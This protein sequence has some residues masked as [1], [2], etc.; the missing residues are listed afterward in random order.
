MCRVHHPWGLYVIEERD[1]LPASLCVT[2]ARRGPWPEQHHLAIV[3]KWKGTRRTGISDRNYPQMCPVVGTGSYVPAVPGGE[4]WGHSGR[5]SKLT[6]NFL[7]SL[8]LLLAHRVL[9]CAHSDL[10]V[11]PSMYSVQVTRFLLERCYLFTLNDRE[12]WAGKRQVLSIWAAWCLQS[13][14]LGGSLHLNASVSPTKL[15]APSERWQF[16]SPCLA[17]KGCSIDISELN[18]KP[19][20]K[21]ITIKS[22]MCNSFKEKK[23]HFLLMFM[24]S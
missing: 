15:K 3:A 19:H 18:C 22:K 13:L 5:L 24:A 8:I 9:L 11:L 12:A 21:T 16:L 2:V 10:W 7:T 20:L 1:G 4:Y 23:L 17:L 6:A 14:V